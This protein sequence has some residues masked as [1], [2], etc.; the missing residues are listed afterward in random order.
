[1][2]LRKVDNWLCANKLSLNLDKTAFMIYSNKN[3]NIDDAIIIR[4][5]TISRVR[6]TKFLGIII[7]DELRFVDHIGL[8]CS[9][10]AKSSGILRKLSGIL[11][12]D[13]LKKI[14]L[15]LIYPYLVYG[16]ECWG[17][18]GRTAINKLIAAQNRCIKLIGRQTSPTDVSAM[19]VEMKL[20]PFTAIYE[21]FSVIKFFKYVILNSNNYFNNKICNLQI[22]HS[23]NTR[24]KT[25]NCLNNIFFTKSKCHNSFV[26]Q[27]IG[28]WNKLPVI[29]R[30]TNSLSSFK[31]LLRNFYDV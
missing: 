21:Y 19:Y 2:E 8:V 29:L 25:N 30:N 5:Q 26:Y 3:K 6:S 11:P 16:V 9:K 22:N 17:A 10:V 12:Y 14:Y 31:R 27:S 24:F 20:L 1:M 13:V 15:S 23:F 18:S 7:D 28:L 4:D